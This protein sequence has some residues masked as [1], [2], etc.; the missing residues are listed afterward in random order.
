MRPPS[1]REGSL[2]S[3][4]H[5]FLT[6]WWSYIFTRL[7]RGFLRFEAGKRRLAESLYRQ[8]GKLAR[9]FIH[10]GMATLAAFGVMIAPVI[11]EELP[12]SSDPWETQS[13]SAVLSA[14]T[15]NPATATLISDK[16]RDR[17]IEYEVQEGDTISGVAQKWG[18]SQETII[19]QNGLRK[20]AVLKPGQTLEILPVTGVSHKVQKGETIYSIAKKFSAEPQAIVDFPFNTFVNDETFAL[21]V[22]QTLIIPDGTPPKEAPPTPTYARRTPDAGT[23]T[24][25]GVFVWP[26]SGNISQRYV[27]YHRGI[28]IA[29]KGAPDILAADSGT[30]EYAG[31]LGWGYGCHVVINHGNGYQTLYAHLSQLY[32]T[33]GQRVARG[34]TIGRMGSTGRSTGTHL[35]FEIRRNGVFLNPLDILR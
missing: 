30:V 19:W 13:P 22:G 18:I 20:N 8:R 12:G 24:G 6:L 21:A 10:S 27:W 16:L 29:N 23:V 9:P 25:S 32:V 2:F 17:I 31:C 15:E 14:A 33:P 35:H 3:Q 5:D 7:K 28:D 34:N 26:A 1:S 4:L 11:A